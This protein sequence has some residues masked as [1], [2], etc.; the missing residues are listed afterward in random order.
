MSAKT[1]KE[2]EEFFG[3]FT[4]TLL[5]MLNFMIA[6]EGG[7]R[8]K[9]IHLTDNLA[10]ARVAKATLH[11]PNW[12]MAKPNMLHNVFVA[13]RFDIFGH[14]NLGGVNNRKIKSTQQSD[15]IG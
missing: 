15:Q 3:D 14:L 13:P 9:K 12:F 4:V 6:R 7:W 2:T 11:S 5:E 8:Q 1:V 10:G